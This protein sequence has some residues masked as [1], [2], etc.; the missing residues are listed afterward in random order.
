LHF[1]PVSRLARTQFHGRED[2]SRLGEMLEISVLLGMASFLFFPVAVGVN[3]QQ[4]ENDQAG[5]KD[6][7]DE[8][9]ISPHL[10]HK[11]RKIGTHFRPTYTTPG[12]KAK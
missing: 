7:D 10:A 5:D 2:V 9:F 8:W 11:T 3:D 12:G 6:D 1:P 4:G